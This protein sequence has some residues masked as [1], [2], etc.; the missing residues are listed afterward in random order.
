MC[1]N[2]P[3]GLMLFFLLFLRSQ[4]ANYALFKLE[5]G[6]LTLSSHLGMVILSVSVVPRV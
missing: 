1:L 4:T 3:F 6:D 5:F 2:C